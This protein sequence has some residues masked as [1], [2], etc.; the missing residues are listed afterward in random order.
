MRN[1][2]VPVVNTG[3][4]SGA[5]HGS[6]KGWLWIIVALVVIAG[7]VVVWRTAQPR[8]TQQVAVEPVG[9]ETPI[10]TTTPP[11]AGGDSAASSDEAAAPTANEGSSPAAGTPTKGVGE[12]TTDT[13]EAPAD[14]RQFVPDVPT[15]LRSGERFVGVRNALEADGWKVHWVGE[16]GRVNCSKTGANLLQISIGQSGATLNAQPITISPAPQ[17]ISDRTMVPPNILKQ[18]TDGRLAVDD[19]GKCYLIK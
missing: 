19:N 15:A 3:G 14:E 4:P 6:G 12:K 2:S 8:E 9:Q 10:P 1:D 11:P 13:A 7:G 16:G 18:A 17:L 5:S